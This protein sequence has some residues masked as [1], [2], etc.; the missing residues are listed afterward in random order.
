MNLALKTC[1]SLESVLDGKLPCFHFCCDRPVPGVL[2]LNDFFASSSIRVCGTVENASGM[3]R[4]GVTIAVTRCHLHHLP[5]HRLEEIEKDNPVL[6]LR[7]YKMLSHLMA[8]REEFTIEQ[9]STLHN[10]MSSPAH[11]KPISRSALRAMS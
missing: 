2:E 4:S 1:D 3:R 8:Y 6:V 11:S 5:F 7:L 10:I 9:L